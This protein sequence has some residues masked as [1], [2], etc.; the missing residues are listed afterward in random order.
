MKQ[1]HKMP[2]TMGAMRKATG[3]SFL[4][5]D[6]TPDRIFTCED[7][8]D[9]HL[10]IARTVDAFWASEVE[11][12]LEAI[13][14]HEPG[15]ARKVLRKAAELGLTAISIPER[16]GGME[17]DLTSAMVVAEHLGKDGSYAGWHSTHTG[18]G[19]LPL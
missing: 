11:P 12:N 2:T 18:I 6:T 17:M 13:R 19:T 7:L 10:D 8:M 5:H 3:G 14:H 15:L 9:E 16:F 4:L 1:R